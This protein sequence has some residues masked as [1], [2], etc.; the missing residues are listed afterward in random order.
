M[1]NV[2]VISP[3]ALWTPHLET[4]LE[5]IQTHLDR[6]D[7][8]HVLVCSASLL[9]CDPNAYHKLGVC[10]ECIGRSKAGL[11]TLSRRVKISPLINVGKDDKNE[12]G[13]LQTE[14]KSLKDLRAFKVD[15]YDLGMGALSSL[16]SELKDPEPN[17]QHPLTKE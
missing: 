5:I 12:I 15:G 14:F 8:V 6:G 2:L 10:L 7:K 4:D 17:L 9:T 1:K 13:H 3:Y 11:K 16:V